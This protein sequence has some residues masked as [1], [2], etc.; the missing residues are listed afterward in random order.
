[1]KVCFDVVL[2]CKP[3]VVPHRDLGTQASPSRTRSPDPKVVGGSLDDDVRT[4]TPPRGATESRATSMLVA[5]LRV[6]SPPCAVEAGEGSTVGDVGVAASPRIIDVDRISAI[7][8]GADDLVKDQPQIDQ[9]P[10]GPGT[11]GTQVPESSS[12]SLRLPW[13]EID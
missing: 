1:V 4:T 3:V 11:S 9:V 6:A 2:L 13:R 7:P 12:S 8:T 10:R 5:D